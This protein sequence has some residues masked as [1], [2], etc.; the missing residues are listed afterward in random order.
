MFLVGHALARPAPHVSKLY[1]KTFG[2]GYRE[3]NIA[4]KIAAISLSN[5]G[6]RVAAQAGR[7]VARRATCSCTPAFTEMPQAKRFDRIVEL[8]GEIF[9]SYEGLVYIAPTGAVVRAIA[10]CLRHKTVDPAV[11]VVDVGGRWA[12]S[13]LGGHE[14]GANEL[15]LAVANILGAEPVVSTTTEA[16]KDLIVGVG[17]RRGA[18][19][20]AIVAAVA[21]GVGA[22][23]LRFGRRC[24]CWLRPT[25]RPTSRDCGEAARQLGLPLRLIPAEEI[26]HTALG[27]RA[28]RVRPGESGPAR[29]CRARRPAGRKENAINTAQ[30]NSARRDG[31]HRAGKLYVLGAALAPYFMSNWTFSMSPMLPLAFNLPVMKAARGLIFFC[32][33]PIM[34][35][36]LVVITMSGLSIAPSCSVQPC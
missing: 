21:R 33:M 1:D 7:R 18:A 3:G 4:V 2:H 23:R 28:F 34:V 15:A 27:V 31:G 26:R 13:L 16:V 22:G 32:V 10:P 35:S 8:T 30:A 25:S 12:V 36:L 9:P 14:G 20:D 19:A 29:G 24:G 6:A 11:V 5:E 17:C